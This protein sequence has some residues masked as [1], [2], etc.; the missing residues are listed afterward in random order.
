MYS[1]TKCLFVITVGKLNIVRV[2]FEA[3]V[4]NL[5]CEKNTCKPVLLVNFS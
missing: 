4:L 3:P 5:F 1:I 2:P